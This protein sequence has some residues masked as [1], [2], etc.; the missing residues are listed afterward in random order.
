MGGKLS[1]PM[2][3]SVYKRMTIEGLMVGV[4]AEAKELMALARAD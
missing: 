3:Q 4:L 2:V 1:L